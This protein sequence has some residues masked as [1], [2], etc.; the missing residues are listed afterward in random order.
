MSEAWTAEDILERDTHSS[1]TRKR[2]TRT[3]RGGI[4]LLQKMG[5]LRGWLYDDPFIEYLDHGEVP[6]YLFVSSKPVTEDTAGQKHELTPK[7]SYSTLVGLTQSRVLIVV[8]REP[9]NET[10]K[11][12]YSDIEQFAIHPESNLSV[13]TNAE[14]KPIEPSGQVRF[15]FN[16]S[17]R[18][19]SFYS[20]QSLTISEILDA[21][22]PMLQQKTNDAEWI[23]KSPWKEAQK[24]YH[25]ATE[26]YEQWLE[27]VQRQVER[28]ED[29]SITTRRLKNIWEFLGDSEQPH[30]YTTGTSHRH[31]I[32]RSQGRGPADSF[33]HQW[34]VFSD[35]RIII[36]NR[37][38]SYE[39]RYP[40]ILKF[41]INERSRKQ[42]ETT[43]KVI[44]L[45]LKT[46]D[47]YH[48]IDIESLS[49]AQ[50]SNLMRF[51]RKQCR[52]R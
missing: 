43:D 7:E 32:I 20:G 12:P 10:R 25:I 49:Q 23:N 48:I 11:I 18:T 27:T 29:S 26:E 39:I 1:V 44:Q 6:K 15:Q 21:L 4:G 36:R 46:P 51:I 42:D 41:T 2:L 37:S 31:H 8:A 35:E 52:E 45:D 40:D 13:Q 38:T 17:R 47:D 33:D 19:I 50:L 28:A 30:Y 24:E 16:T 22:G 3:R 34:S 5:L 9:T 14:G